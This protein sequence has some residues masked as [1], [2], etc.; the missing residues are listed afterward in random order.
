[1]DYEVRIIVEKVSVSTQEVV[2]R[3]TVK[4]YNLQCPKSIF[5]LG[6]GHREQISLLQKVQDA[7]LA[8]QSALID[9]DNTVCPSCG[10]KLRKDGYKISDFHAVFS[11]HKLRL[12]KHRCSNSECGWQQIP[13]I[14]SKFGTNIH[15]D[16]AKLQC[17][18]GALYSYREAQSNLEQLNCQPR[19]VNN[20]NQV[21]LITDRV[22][23]ALSEQNHI[24]PTAD[25][26]AAPAENL[27]VQMDSGHIPIQDKTKRSFEA[28]SAV[29]YRLD[30][31]QQMNRHYHHGARTCVLSAIDDQLKTIK[32]FLLNAALKQGISHNTKVTAL[33]DGARNC[34]SVLS[35]LEAECKQFEWILDW[36]HIAKE[37][38]LV[39]NA[40]GESLASSLDGVKSKLWHGKPEEALTQLRLLRHQETDAAKQSQL[41]GLYNYIHHNQLY[42][43]NYHERD[44]ANQV[45]TSQVAES[46]AS[47]IHMRHKRTGKMQWTRAGAHNVLQIRAKM[48]S[49]EWNEQ[50]QD[51]VLAALRVAV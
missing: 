20:H 6:L 26:C 33:A 47:I 8:E 3:D 5:D 17:E 19:P 7:L 44:R 48:T 11:D 24:P 37:F 23:A 35:V 45:Y 40:L 4:T 2:K 18:Q 42:I 16:L 46:L 14:K 51:A 27:I 32:T 22:G 10:K 31:L 29:V 34:W 15:P 41:T 50:W 9:S 28:L 25:E 13:T 21:K 36:F 38:Q 30:N 49:N 43:I 1:M 39:R 12:Q